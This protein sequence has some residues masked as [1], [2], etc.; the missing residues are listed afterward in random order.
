MQTTPSP[1][2]IVLIHGLWMTPLSWE[3]WIDRYTKAGFRVLAPAWP[4]M[5]GSVEQLRADTTPYAHLGV[6]EIVEHYAAI[7]EQLETPPIVMGHSFGGA[8]TEILLDRGLGCAGGMTIDPAPIK[9]VLRL[10]L[11]SLRSSFPA[12]KDPRNTHKAVMLTPEEFH[13]SFTNTLTDEQSAKVY[14]RYAVPGPG[15][16]L[17]Q[18][19]LANFN[20]HAAT[21]VDF[22]NDARAPL[23]IIGGGVDHVVPA[24]V[25][26]EVAGHYRNSKALTEYKEFAGRSHY[27]LGQNGWE[28][29]ADYALDWARNHGAPDTAGS[30]SSSSSSSEEPMG[31]TLVL[32]VAAP[33]NHP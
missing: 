4:G 17:F 5:D 27:T 32:S 30:S 7:I 18:A 6:T 29:V 22:D 23:L 11:S 25:T 15:R 13:Y 16:V 28:E 1:A 10:P 19:A 12:L 14:E 20:P 33:A 24:A 2:T 31:E 21:R 8:F 9:G 26:K 3:R